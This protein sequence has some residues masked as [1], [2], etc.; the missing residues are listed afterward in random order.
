MP[1]STNRGLV[2][3][4]YGTVSSASSRPVGSLETLSSRRVTFA[5]CPAGI[6]AGVMSRVHMAHEGLDGQLITDTGP[7]LTAGAFEDVLLDAL[8]VIRPSSRGDLS[9]GVEGLRRGQTGLVIAV[10]GR[11][12]LEEARQLAASRHDGRGGIAV[13][14]A[15][16]SWAEPSGENGNGNGK[17][18][19]QQEAP[20]ET[21]PAA[22]VL[23]AAG[24]RV[25]S[26]DARTPLSV[27]WLRLPGAGA[28]S[29]MA[30]ARWR[31]EEPGEA[32]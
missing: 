32:V 22:S 16:S 8:S 20:D 2:P 23:R 17:P 24:W 26:M 25:V 4:A 9:R 19:V 15:V 13:L 6:L 12:T 27:A 21:A 18:A 30:S 5:V 28:L 29:Q 1:S 3:S 31:P 10:T 11:L 14:L 7:I